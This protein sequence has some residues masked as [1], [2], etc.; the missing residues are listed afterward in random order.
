[1]DRD[2][3]KESINEPGISSSHLHGG[4]LSAQKMESSVG[5]QASDAWSRKPSWEKGLDK[6]VAF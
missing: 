1:M 2:F 3:D 4:M 6:Q 5:Y